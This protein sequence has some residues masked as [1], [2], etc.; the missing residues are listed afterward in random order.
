MIEAYILHQSVENDFDFIVL[1]NVLM[2]CISAVFSQK[3]ISVN[4]KLETLSL[5]WCE[6]IEIFEKL[7]P[8]EFGPIESLLVV[9][10]F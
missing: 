8:Y 4:I 1:C 5:L 6:T 2:L 10:F 7:L 3:G 9:V